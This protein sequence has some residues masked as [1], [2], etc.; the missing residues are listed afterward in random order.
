MIDSAIRYWSVALSE[1][2]LLSGARNGGLRARIG[3]RTGE[4]VM[5]ND[6]FSVLQRH[7][8]CTRREIFSVDAKTYSTRV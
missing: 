8:Q 5:R 2:F 3:F 7:I 6:I 4:P 1:I